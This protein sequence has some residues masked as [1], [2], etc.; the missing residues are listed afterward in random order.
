MKKTLLLITLIALV[1]AILVYLA[2]RQTTKPPPPVVPEP[3]TT[4]IPTIF[5]LISIVST[6]PSAGETNVATNQA[7]VVTF[8]RRPSA[9]EVIF[10]LAPTTPYQTIWRENTLII[11]PQTPLSPGTLYTYSIS[12]SDTSRIPEVYTFTTSGP[13]GVYQ[14][15]TQPSGAAEKQQKFLRENYPDIYLRGFI[16]YKA[17]SFSITSDYRLEPEGHYYFV[18]TLLGDKEKSKTE[19]VAWLRSLGLTEAQIQSLDISYR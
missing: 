9:G 7:I 12:F 8:N 5:T 15:D 14:P 17:A 10:T 3:S 6:R 18:F 16:P 19:A 2:L 11:T 1:A 13:P 4:P